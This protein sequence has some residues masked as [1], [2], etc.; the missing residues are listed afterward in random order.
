[1]ND[2]AKGQ[3][4]EMHVQAYF[5]EQ[6]LY[7][8]PNI[9]TNGA[10]IDLVTVNPVTGETTLYDVK[11]VSVTKVNKKYYEYKPRLKPE[12]IRL[13]VKLIKV[14]ADGKIEIEK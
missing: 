5:L 2:S 7:V 8:F 13:G 6:G 1:M 9:M 10:Y 14:Y 3:I 11:F 12:Q 4:T